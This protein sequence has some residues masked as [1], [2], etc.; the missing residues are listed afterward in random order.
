MYAGSAGSFLPNLDPNRAGVKDEGGERG[1]EGAFC[2]QLGI[3]LVS[4]SFPMPM[5]IP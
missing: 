5:P 4:P 2:E 1:D 3:G